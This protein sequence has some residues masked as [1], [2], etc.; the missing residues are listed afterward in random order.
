MK[1]KSLRAFCYLLYMS[2]EI[3]QDILQI[4]LKGFSVLKLI[5]K[6]ESVLIRQRFPRVTIT[7]T[8]NH[9]Y[10]VEEGYVMRYLKQLRGGAR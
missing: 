5:T 4:E 10:V 3:K 1:L 7:K 6:E 8:V 2:G 9:Y